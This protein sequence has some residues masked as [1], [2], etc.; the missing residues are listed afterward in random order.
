M[1]V[2]AISALARSRT[3]LELVM[4]PIPPITG[5]RNTRKFFTDLPSRLQLRCRRT[6]LLEP[7]PRGLGHRPTFSVYIRE[8]FAVIAN[9]LS[10]I[11]E[12]SVL[13]P[14]ALVALC[15]QFEKDGTVP[16]GLPPKLHEV[17]KLRLVVR[18]LLA[19]AFDCHSLLA[20]VAPHHRRWNSLTSPTVLPDNVPSDYITSITT[21]NVKP[22]PASCFTEDALPG[23]E[24]RRNEPV[25]YTVVWSSFCGV[26]G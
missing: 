17:S 21:V 5:S 6:D 22:R 13:Q 16:A 10:L 20:S 23:N 2:A 24:N 15:N 9:A 25:R 12:A 4:D 1:E 8:V 11:L 18:D 3:L 26:K 7:T 14:Y 19:D